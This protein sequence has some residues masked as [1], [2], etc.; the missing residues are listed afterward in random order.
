VKNWKIQRNGRLARS[1][2]DD[3]VLISP[4]SQIKVTELEQTKINRRIHDSISTQLNSQIVAFSSEKA[5]RF[6]LVN[7]T[8]K[9]EKPRF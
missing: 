8:S 2:P 4:F 1:T 5:N 6:G 3:S 9:L 7:P